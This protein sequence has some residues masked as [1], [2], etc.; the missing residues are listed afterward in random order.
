MSQ[1]SCRPSGPA[2]LHVEKLL[3]R[4]SSTGLQV[5]G[6]EFKHSSL[7]SNQP[8]GPL[9]ALQVESGAPGRCDHVLRIAVHATHEPLVAGI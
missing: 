1:K 3:T 8:I 5:T 2:M 9:V 6:V 7:N 4:A